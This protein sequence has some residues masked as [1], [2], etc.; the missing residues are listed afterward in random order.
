MR[1]D[2]TTNNV[3][4]PWKLSGTDVCGMS[5]QV[6]VLNGSVME[7]HC[8]KSSLPGPNGY[9]MPHFPMSLTTLDCL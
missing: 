7:W 2:N 9:A 3:R 1:E 5:P 6:E 8:V 4:D